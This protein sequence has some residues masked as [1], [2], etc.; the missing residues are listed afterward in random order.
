MEIEM[1]TLLESV[2]ARAE[3]ECDLTWGTKDKSHSQSAFEVAHLAAGGCF[4]P[5]L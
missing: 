3:G 4:F 5:F 2:E 1:P